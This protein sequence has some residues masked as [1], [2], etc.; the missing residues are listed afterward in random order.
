MDLRRAAKHAL[1]LVSGRF[2][3]DLTTESVTLERQG[4]YV[5]WGKGI[6][7]SWQAEDDS[8]VSSPSGG[9]RY[10]HRYLQVVHARS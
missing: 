8:V 3:L 1:I 5:V 4:D 7:Q 9:H 2:R 10:G 6:D